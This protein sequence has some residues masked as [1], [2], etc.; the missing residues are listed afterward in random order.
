MKK[1]NLYNAAHVFTKLF[2][3][4]LTTHFI[5]SPCQ[6]VV[7]NMKGP[8]IFGLPNGSGLLQQVYNT[9]C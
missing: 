7:E 9:I 6:Q 2:T 1:I 3:M 4:I 8:L 5:S